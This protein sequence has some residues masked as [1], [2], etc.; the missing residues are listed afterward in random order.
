[1]EAFFVLLH[2]S[3]NFLTLVAALKAKILISQHQAQQAISV[4]A[5][6]KSEDLRAKSLTQP[7]KVTES[8]HSLFSTIC[9][10][11]EAILGFLCKGMHYFDIT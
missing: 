10:Y 4:V 9:R 7:L 5:W 8:S 3:Q 1:M 6:L 11:G 2:G